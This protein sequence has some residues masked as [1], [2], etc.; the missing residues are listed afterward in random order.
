MDTDRREL[1]SVESEI[2]S[3]RRDS[4]G[5]LIHHSLN[6]TLAEM[7]PEIIIVNQKKKKQKASARNKS[8]NTHY[9]S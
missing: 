7:G 5:S 8:N 3:M 6:P 2:N 1:E 4:H 9:G